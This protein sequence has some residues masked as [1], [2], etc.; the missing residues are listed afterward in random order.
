M[1]SKD[2]IYTIFLKQEYSMEENMRPYSFW[3]KENFKTEDWKSVSFLQHHPNT[4]LN[5][6]EIHC[7]MNSKIHPL[8]SQTQDIFNEN[9]SEKEKCSQVQL[10]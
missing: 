7:N 4:D 2:N 10:V 6:H 3:P 1:F 5:A 8:F 9:H